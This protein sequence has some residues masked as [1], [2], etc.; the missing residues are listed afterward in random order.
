MMLPLRI[1]NEGCL[2]C[3]GHQGYKVGDQRGGVSASVSMAPYLALAAHMR[4]TLFV[5]HGV[6]WILGLGGIGYVYR[7][8]GKRALD[9][10]EMDLARRQAEGEVRRLNAELEQRVI[11]RTVQLAAANQE[12]ESFAYSVSHDLR[13]P[14]RSIDGFSQAL[15]EDYKDKVD[16]E[17]QDYL[18]RVRAAAQ[19]MAQLI[20]DILKLSRIT[21]NEMTHTEV[22]LTALAREVAAELR[23]QEPQRQVEFVIAEGLVARGDPRL[24]RVVLEN[25]LGNAWKFTAH[26]EQAQI[27]FGRTEAGGG[28]ALF[29]RDNGAGFDMAWVDKLFAPFQ[30]LHSEQEFPGTGIGLALVQRI[31]YRHGGRIWAEGKVGEGATFHFT[32]NRLHKGAES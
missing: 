8:A 28:P 14:L 31:V 12:L 17:G 16:E 1:E 2:K 32:L 18:R 4:Q 10:L 3:H 6:A 22:D 27:E 25:L 15:L 7:R 11:E 23:E 21:R 5:S 29:V 26:R 9:R 24:Q 13:A 30:R 19:R 20:D